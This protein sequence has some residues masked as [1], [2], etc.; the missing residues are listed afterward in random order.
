MKNQSEL[1]L[2]PHGP[3]FR[4]VHELELLDPGKSAVGRYTISGEEEFLKGHFPGQPIW[5][6]VVM[7]EAIA[8]LGGVVAQSDPGHAKLDDMR[9]TAV[10]N[11][12]ILGTAEPGVVLTVEAKVEGRMG[13][14]IQVS[15]SVS[16]GERCLARGVVML[17][18]S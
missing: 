11:A 6:G 9:L 4:F 18:G 1:E 5:P 8:Q 15:G 10:K 13:P 17:S 7:I 14:L 12:K 3:E 16:A 2:L